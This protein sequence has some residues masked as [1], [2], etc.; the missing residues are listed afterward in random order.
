MKRKFTVKQRTFIEEYL[1]D[2]NATQAAIRAGYSRKTAKE[3]GCENL[4]KPNIQE[5]IRVAMDERSQRTGVTVDRVLAAIAKI[6]FSDIREIFTGSGKLC[7]ITDLPDDIATAIQSIDVVARPIDVS[8]DDIKEVEHVYKIKLSDKLKGL[9]LLGK[10]L[11]MFDSRFGMAQR[12]V[13]LNMNYG[14]AET[15][16]NIGQNTIIDVDVA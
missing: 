16:K 2:L 13:I 8:D 3:I 5:A 10:H 15:S 1:V 12:S 7:P 4:S 9:E 6:G 11:G 14:G